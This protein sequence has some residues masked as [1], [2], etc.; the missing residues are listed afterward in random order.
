MCDKWRM[1]DLP[2]LAKLSVEEKDDLIRVLWPLKARVESLQVGITELTVKVAELEGRLALTSRNSSKPPSTD[3][4]TKPPPK[5]KSLRVAGQNPSGGQKGHEGHTLKKV[6]EPDCVEKHR[7]AAHCD[8]CQRSLSE[9]VVVESRQVFDLPDLRHKVTEHQVTE[10][11]CLCGKVHR[12]AFPSAVTAPVQY[13]PRIKAAVVSLTDDHMMPVAR[14]SQVMDDFFG[15]PISDG[16]I[17][18][19][20]EEAAALLAPTVD[21]IGEACQLTPVLHADETGMRVA[22]KLHWLHIYATITMTWVACHAKRGTEAFEALGILPVYLGTLIH[23][24]WKPYRELLCKHGLCNAHHLRELTYQFEEMKQVWA[25][26]MIALLVAAC[27]EVGAVGGPLP[28]GRI[29]YYRSAYEQILVEGEAANPRVSP[30]PGK[31]G[32]TAQS[33]GFNLLNRLRIYKDDVWRFATDPNTP[34]T[35]NI[36]EQAARMNKVKQKIAG[37]FRTKDGIDRYCINRSYM[38]T[39]RKQG[40]N[41]YESLVLTFEGKTPQ[42]NF[43]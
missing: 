10:T 38:A 21:R 36:A 23:D 31:K 27:R 14:T 39:L 19:A 12:G 29:A 33:K 16:T 34:F 8:A 9:G 26:K 30:A 22:G 25:E 42:P 43:A 28:E 7:P 15:L 20:K 11:K 37:C 4:L 6:D 24:G 2:D 13:G 5:P 35:N 17:Q 41:I 40:G 3:G 1:D 32:K 18:V